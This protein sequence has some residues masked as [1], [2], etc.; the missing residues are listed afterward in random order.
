[1][2]ALAAFSVLTYV[3]PSRAQP[4]PDAVRSAGVTVAQW[5]EVQAEV[6]RAAA[7]RG[8]SER[9]LAAVAGRMGANLVIDGR[10][11]LEDL[12]NS[13][14]ERAE[15]VAELQARIAAMEAGDDPAVAGLLNE[16]RQAIERGDLV[17]GDALLAQAAER[18]LASIDGDETQLS[19]RRPRA[20]DAIAERARLAQ[21]NADYLAAANL[22]A[23]ASQLATGS[24]RWRYKMSGADALTER[25]RV[26]YE[27]DSLRSAE[28]IYRNELDFLGPML[29]IEERA[30][31]RHRL[32]LVLRLIGQRGVNTSLVQAVALHRAAL[33][34]TTRG[35]WPAAWANG[36]V[37][38]GN[39]LVMLGERTN[40]P[41]LLR[42]AI[43]A[44]RMALQVF[45]REES[46]GNWATT[47]NNLG[48]T[49]LQLGQRG[50]SEALHEAIAVLREA[51]QVRTRA[52]NP[53]SWAVT[54]NHLGAALR[55]LGEY[56]DDAAL[57]EAIAIHRAALGV[58]TRQTS[59]AEWARTQDHLGLA[60]LARARRGDDAA[61]REAVSS[62]RAALEVRTRA[63]APIDWAKTQ[64]NLGAAL[65]RSAN[66]VMRRRSPK[67]SK[68]IAGRSKYRAGSWR[69]GT[70]RQHNTI[71]PA[72]SGCALGA[73]SRPP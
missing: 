35:R 45:T 41:A 60:L 17:Q 18:D 50:D 24:A 53:R 21:V 25:G 38:L 46:T 12:L 20:A 71:L 68:S 16:A 14:D 23:Q 55:T 28:A 52:T 62:F 54:Q 64:T 5:Q 6:R 67:R 48:S 70:G 19:R 33:Q 34:E 2:I 10:I 59:P 66:E 4:L 37:G 32:G 49:L 13:I 43:G 58:H 57:E 29:S 31:T 42:E 44:Y 1:M 72:R 36:Q 47:H 39:A 40:D 51:L 22:Y 8:A 69:R 27:I 9:A 73:A 61:L 26:F 63:S 56:G 65:R 7:A 30:S 3:S 15:Q 11:D